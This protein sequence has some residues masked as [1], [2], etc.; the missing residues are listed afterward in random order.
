MNLSEYQEKSARTLNTDLSRNEAISNYSMGLAGETGEAVDILKKHI[1]HKHELDISE[2]EK[3]LGD[4]MWYI[5][6]LSTTL[7][8]DLNNI[9][10]RNIFKLKK[11]YPNKFN[12][13]D[14]KNREVGEEILK[15]EFG[16][17]NY[18]NVSENGFSVIRKKVIDEFIEELKKYKESDSE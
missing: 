3:E 4:I 14:S 7:G 9:A 10:Q 8:L 1:Y 15:Q 18:F 16:E 13:E 5:A 11:R 17:D 6:A 2:I 12:I